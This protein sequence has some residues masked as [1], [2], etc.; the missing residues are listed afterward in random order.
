[1]LD[2]DLLA[3]IASGGLGQWVQDKSGK[4]AYVK[5]DDCLGEGAWWGSAGRRPTS[6]RKAKEHTRIILL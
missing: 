5:S 1:M 3:S 4:Q 6:T 2:L